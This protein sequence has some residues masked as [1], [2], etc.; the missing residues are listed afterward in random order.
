MPS[1]Y[2]TY[3]EMYVSHSLMALSKIIWLASSV[4]LRLKDFEAVL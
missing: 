1:N 2:K 3:I 4:I